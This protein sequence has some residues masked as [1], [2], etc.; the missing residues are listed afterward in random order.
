MNIQNMFQKDINRDI[1]GV[2]KVSQN[3][4]N[5]L[6][7]ELSEYIITKEL[8][9]HFRTFFDNYSKAIDYPPTKS[10]CGFPASLEAVNL[11]F[12]NIVIPS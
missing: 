8:R 6:H 5:S 2:I 10:A 12:Q 4:D 1:N 11:T 9:R 7:Q 3:D